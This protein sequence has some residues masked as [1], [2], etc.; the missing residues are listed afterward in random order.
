MT[1]GQLWTI[2]QKQWKQIILCF[3]LVG[4]G[5]Y[6]V[7]K[8]IK[9]TYQSA[10]LVQ[11]TLHSSSNQS[12][13]NSLLASD[14]LVQTEVE[15]ATSDQVIR[16]V[17]SHYPGLSVETL[18]KKVTATSKINTQLFEIDVQ[19]A[20]AKNAATYANDVATTL[21]KQQLLETQLENAHSQQ[22]LQQEMDSTKQ[23]ID[24]L[25]TQV[26]ALENQGG[27]QAQ[28]TVLQNQ[29]TGLQQH[30]SQWQSSLAQL[31][32][33]E[34][35]NG[36]Y[37]RIAQ[38]AQQPVTPIRPQVLLNTAIGLGAGLLLGILLAV[39]FEQLDTRVRTAE[40]LS[41]LL[42]WP[43]LATVQRVNTSKGE[44]VINPQGHST[45]VEAY[46]ILRTNIGF[47]SIDKPLHS[48]AVT[49]ALP[50]EGKSTTASNLAIFMAKAGKNTL[51]IDA[52][53]RRPSLHEKF[54]LFAENI[55]LS[56]AIITFA[57]PQFPT[58]PTMS[59][60]SGALSST[61]F[62][63]D[64]FM[65]NVGIPNL[66]VM[67]SGPLP[68]NPSEL[69][70]S[71]ASARLFTALES[72]GAEIIIFD[73]PPLLD[74]SDTSILSSKVDGT[75]VVA[76]ISSA[77]KENMSRVKAILAQANAKVIGCVANK[78]TGRQKGASY[79]YYYYRQE[80][81]Q[82]DEMNGKNTKNGSMPPAPNTPSL[83]MTPI[84]QK[85]QSN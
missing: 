84:P 3:L 66:R 68:P 15:L 46:R 37:L 28:I 20:S 44:E 60:P 12:D 58:K 62:A 33:S 38:P 25:T 8:F 11:I 35:Q 72:C 76:D 80:E 81:V 78:E 73:T 2:V 63:L 21:I 85:T 48:L 67:P 18:S 19:D 24:S 17:A 75:L 59:H 10:V 54:G 39:L 9:P 31:E 79:A 4:I 6:G 43:V 42:G 1:F 74:L 30:Y 40:Q 51:L 14:Q 26:I 65:H 82:Q 50:R 47:S 49:S 77:K 7:S 41:E 5:T 64:P 34:A 52:D 71:K 83:P 16:E 57:Q 36:D 45:N 27:K 56:N 61:A 32:L 23:Q 29:L 13:Y 53:L 69:L 22:Q 70:D 55:G